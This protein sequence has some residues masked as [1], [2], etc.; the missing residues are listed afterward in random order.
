VEGTVD[1]AYETA[2]GFVVV[3]FKTDRADAEVIAMYARQVQLYADAI[4]QATGKPAR[5]VLMSV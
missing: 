2:D 5:S 1:L 4:S 3:D